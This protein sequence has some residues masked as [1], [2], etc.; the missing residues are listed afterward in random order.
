MKLP[1]V[2]VAKGPE[3]YYEPAVR[4]LPQ[5]EIRGESSTERLLEDRW[6][7]EALKRG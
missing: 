5:A 4:E 3:D 2:F 6:R 7:A 1:E